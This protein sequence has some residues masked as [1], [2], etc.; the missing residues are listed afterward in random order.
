[1]HLVFV[2]SLVPVQNPVSGF[3]IANRAV[4]EGLVALGHRVSVLGFAEAADRP[5]ATADLHLLGRM[6]VTNAKVGRARKARW[7]LTA[8]A[9]GL[10]ISVAKMRAVSEATLKDE[11]A[12]LD[13]IDGLVLNSVQL[14]G[15][16]IDH[17][18][19]YPTVYVA[20]NVEAGTARENAARAR[21]LVSRLLFSREAR[22]LAGIETRLTAQA[23]WV[24]T[25]SEEDRF[26][27][28]PAVAAKSSCLP[29]VTRWDAP[30]ALPQVAS[31][32]DL[33]LIGTWSWEANRIGL[34]WFVNAVVPL[35]PPHLTIAV[36]GQIA[37][38]PV[39]T[40]PGLSFIGRVADAGEFLASVRLVPLIA[41]AG[42]GVQLKTIETFERGLPCVATPASVRGIDALPSFCRLADTPEAFAA[43]IL[44]V[45]AGPDLSAD[46]EAGRH[47][48]SAQKAR[49][50]AVL[51]DGLAHLGQ[52]ADRRA[53]A[54]QLSTSPVASASGVSFAT[55]APF[56]GQ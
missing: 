16:F 17:F 40:H 29:L 54:L 33:G 53:A 46:A 45:L 49:L 43:A 3:A 42:S 52:P 39:S 56:G 15:A 18:Q 12:S 22:L 8:I 36:A 7:F 1:M 41:R 28:G 31:R 9:A 48:H 38:P 10:P 23:D 50:Q 27:F 55:P 44:S 4:F 19:T 11:L 37:V 26:G 51:G 24:F 25:F 20:H 13:P 5:L 34:D 47:F 6:D 32:Y 21:G 2:T 35:L 14:P 30:D